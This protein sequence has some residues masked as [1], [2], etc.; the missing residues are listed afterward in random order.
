MRNPGMLYELPDGRKVIVYTGKGKQPFAEQKN[1]IICTLVDDKHNAIMKDDKP[2][3]L[4]RSD[5]EVRT[6]KLIGFID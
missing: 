2:A 4:I 1:K 3:T 6:Y 5:L